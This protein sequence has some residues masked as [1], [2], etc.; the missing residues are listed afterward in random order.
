MHRIPLLA[1]VLSF[2]ACGGGGGG[3][4]AFGVL[5]VAE[6]EANETALTANAL[7]EGRA[8]TG[9]IASPTDVD[10]WSFPAREGEF[11]T[12]ELV[13]TR[14]DQAGWDA[15]CNV[16]RL[17]LWD[18]DGLTRLLE[19]NYIDAWPLG[20]H[21][22]D[23]PL[24]R[25][26]A[27]GTYFVCVV[28]DAPGADGAEYALT[29][30]RSS[31]GAVQTETELVGQTGVNDTP[32]SA[33]AITANRLQGHHQDGN[34][35]WYRFTAARAS[36][37]CVEMV[38][39][40][41]GRYRTQAEYYAPRLNLYGADGATLITTV[42]GV[43]FDDP[44]LCAILPTGGVY[45]VEVTQVA[46]GG[47][48][49]YHLSF[50]LRNADTLPIETEINDSALTADAVFYGVTFQ[51]SI[52][53]A[54]TDFFSFAG[55]AGDQVLVETLPAVAGT[56]ML[57]EF[58][59]PDGAT[60]QP[61]DR[62]TFGGIVS[63]RTI[64]PQS[65]TYFFRVTA[66]SAQPMGYVA[67][68]SRPRGAG[69]ESESNGTIGNA[70]SFDEAGRA[71]GVIG[72]D[73]DIDVFRLNAREGE[74][75]VVSILAKRMVRGAV[76]SDGFRTLSGNGS[77]LMPRLRALTDTGAEIARSVYTPPN[78]CTSAESVADGLPTLSVAF[79]A[80]VAGT[81]FIEVAAEDGTGGP[82]HTYILQRR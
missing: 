29:I 31:L 10:F 3:G 62:N 76:G 46:A 19:H 52:S 24:W 38:S 27:T 37:L 49:D 40:R 2:A 11:L 15:A 13:A 34:P 12:I 48:A 14:L 69:F 30:R 22:M 59:A 60:V 28:S 78:A 58:F 57:V 56:Q 42:D 33:Q 45:F 71:A 21:D 4:P 9:L 17:T 23:I 80:P 70:D 25:V 63:T 67:A 79:V 61:G 53:T 1:I 16:G 47:D 20:R 55:T 73:V 51:G 6:Q 72:S 66:L 50:S 43:Y 64:L 68:L 39:S 7:P 26:P 81:Y 18:T 36:V 41:N 54:D 8:G 32:L 5:V 82:S 75:V 44:F 35:D 74:L 77:Q 65:G